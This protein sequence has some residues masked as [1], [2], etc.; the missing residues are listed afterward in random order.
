MVKISSLERFQD[1]WE[2]CI[3]NRLSSVSTVPKIQKL[4]VMVSKI[5]YTLLA[6][7]AATSCA[8]AES[9]VIVEAVGGVSFLPG[10]PAS[11]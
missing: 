9:P 11:Q 10:S 6:S 8:L 4:A 3:S 1:R 7:N 2:A 5:E